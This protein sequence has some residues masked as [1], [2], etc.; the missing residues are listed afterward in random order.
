VGRRHAVPSASAFLPQ[1]EKNAQNA[2]KI[3][4]SLTHILH[5][6]N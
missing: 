1:F 2:L 6:E 5:P 3:V 4:S